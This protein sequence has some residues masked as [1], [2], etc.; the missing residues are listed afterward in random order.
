MVKTATDSVLPTEAVAVSAL[1]PRDDGT[2]LAP[3]G[4][5]AAMAPGDNAT[6][7]PQV[8]DYVG[9]KTEVRSGKRQHWQIYFAKVRGYL[10][11]LTSA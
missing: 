10:S 1:A 3:V 9:V 7:H 11:L 2:T 5:D 4:D 6:A 8:N